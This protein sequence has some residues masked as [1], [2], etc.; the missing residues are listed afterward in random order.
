M[1]RTSARVWS[2][3]SLPSSRTTSRALVGGMG[4]SSTT[5]TV[6]NSLPLW[7]RLKRPPLLA[8]LGS[9]TGFLWTLCHLPLRSMAEHFNANFRVSRFTCCKS[10][11]IFDTSI[12]YGVSLT[13]D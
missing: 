2:G 11:P 12:E 1:A 7:T 3:R 4:S 10:A 9:V 6:T 8:L 5:S 13:Y